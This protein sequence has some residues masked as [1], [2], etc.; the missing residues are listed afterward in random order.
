MNDQKTKG[1]NRGHWTP[2]SM[3]ACNGR[4]AVVKLLLEKR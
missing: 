2:L 1:I 4:E 3:A